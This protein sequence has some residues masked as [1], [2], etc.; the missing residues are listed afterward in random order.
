MTVVNIKGRRYHHPLRVAKLKK[1][2]DSHI[3][4]P[5]STP[6]HLLLLQRRLPR[7]LAQPV[8]KPIQHPPA[9]EPLQHPTPPRHIPQAHVPRRPAHTEHRVRRR[10][11]EYIRGQRAVRLAHR[12]AVQDRVDVARVEAAGGQAEAD[13]RGLVRGDV[14]ADCAWGEEDDGDVQ[15]LALHVERVGERVQRRFRRAVDSAPWDGSAGSE[16]S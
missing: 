10:T 2:T 8:P 5:P 11:R 13:A 3:Q 15:G 1:L 16:S 9:R 4:R 12:E 14:R 6:G 7:P